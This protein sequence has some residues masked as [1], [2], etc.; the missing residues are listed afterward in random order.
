MRAHSTHAA[1]RCAG[2]SADGSAR[3]PAP[4][5]LL[6]LLN[7]AEPAFDAPLIY[8]LGGH[9]SVE[10]LLPHCSWGSFPFSQAFLNTSENNSSGRGLRLTQ[11]GQ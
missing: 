8:R 3:L 5:L 7:T 11:P 4:W 6:T 9:I 10:H 1:R 2:D